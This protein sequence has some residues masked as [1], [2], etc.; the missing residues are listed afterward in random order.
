MGSLVSE[1]IQG[2]EM[3]PIPK[4]KA[5]EKSYSLTQIFHGNPCLI[6][7]NWP[8]WVIPGSVKENQ[9]VNQGPIPMREG[10]RDWKILWSA[11][12]NK[13]IK[14]YSNDNIYQNIHFNSCKN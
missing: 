7:Q 10:K 11:E 2:G 12:N 8:S 13:N 5:K 1:Q 3:K 14:E 9:R 6:I 4:G